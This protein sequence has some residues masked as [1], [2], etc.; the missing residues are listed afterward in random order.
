MDFSKTGGP[1]RPTLGGMVLEDGVRRWEGMTLFDYF[2]GQFIASG[3][4]PADAVPFAIE[5]MQARNKHL[6]EETA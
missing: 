2:V 3:C 6:I 4:E 5:V 1:M